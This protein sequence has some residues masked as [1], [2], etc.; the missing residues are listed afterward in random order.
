M[1]RTVTRVRGW[2]LAMVLAVL[3]L[4]ACMATVGVNN[5]SVPKNSARIC[6]GHCKSIGM[7]LS[8]V[9]IMA[10]NVG[11]VCQAGSA[12]ASDEEASNDSG[13]L[14]APAAGM[15]TIALQ[16]A[17]DAQRRQALAAQHH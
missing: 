9:A 13:K 5:Y 1:S 3:P 16:A 6:A 8:A 15:A 4:G 10:E 17:A 7:T 2:R 11:C 12:S 14:S